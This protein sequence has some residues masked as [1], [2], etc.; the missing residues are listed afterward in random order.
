MQAQSVAGDWHGV[1]EAGGMK[2]RLVFH[3]QES[4]KGFTATMDSPDQGA[5]GIPV[6]EV[7]LEDKTLTIRLAKLGISYQGDLA[8]DGKKI[9]GIFQQGPARIPLELGREVQDK[10]VVNRPQEPQPPFP[11]REEEVSYDNTQAEGVQLAGTLSLPKGDG[12]FPAVVLISGSGPQNRNEELLGHKP[13]LIIA[14]HFSRAGIAVLRFDDRGVGESTGDFGAATSKDFATDVQAGI[15]F[16]K[17]RPDINASQIGLVGHSEGGLIGPMVAADNPDVAFLVLMAGPGVPGTDILLLQQELMAR[18]EGS[19]EEEIAMTR[20]TSERVFRDLEKTEDLEKTKEEL[21]IYMKQ[22]LEK[23]PA[24]D[25]E[26]LGDLDQLVQQQ[27]K[28]ITTPWFR[29]FLSYDPVE[30]LKKVDCPVLAIN[31]E[32][33]LQVDA[34]QNLPVIAE[35][36][37]AA[38]NDRV[39]TV[40]LSGLNHLFQHSD[41]GKASEYGQLEETFAPEAL[42]LMT[43]W[44]KEQI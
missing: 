25:Q 2:L 14:D 40:V 7:K 35:A 26:K 29:F 22:E 16:L 15:D 19:S 21:T 6:D 34:E 43:E 36:L 11:Y 33:D 12:P 27:L 20:Q 39:K 37:K 9:S 8:A 3:L 38:G 28:M 13:F 30:M 31:G 10:P 23:L 1:L 17:T 24:A 32:K 18:A 4:D 41:S 5:N 44:I 42:E